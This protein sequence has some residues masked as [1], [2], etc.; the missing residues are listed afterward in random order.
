MFESI[1]ALSAVVNRLTEVVKTAV[2]E[3]V[4]FSDDATAW[5]TLVISLL[6]GVLAALFANANLFADPSFAVH[7]D[8]TAGILLTGLL[9]GF[10]SNALHQ[11]FDLINAVKDVLS[12]PTATVSQTTTTTP[13]GTSTTTQTKVEGPA[14]PVTA[15]PSSATI[16]G[17][18]PSV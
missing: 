13:T 15:P 10:G 12:A 5:L 14:V 11:V 7:V 17:T 9:I 6:I 4:K 2:L 1:L 8:P 18:P 16:P 3:K